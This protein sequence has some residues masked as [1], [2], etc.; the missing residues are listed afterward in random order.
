MVVPPHAAQVSAEGSEYVF[1]NSYKCKMQ[2]RQ[3][4]FKSVQSNLMTCNVVVTHVAAAN[5]AQLKALSFSR[6]ICVDAQNMSELD[7][8]AVISKN[9]NQLVLMGDH[10][11]L[12][13]VLKQRKGLFYVSRGGQIS[14][15]ERLIRQG[16]APTLLNVQHANQGQL[17]EFRSNMFY[18]SKLSYVEVRP[19]LQPIATSLTQPR[20]LLVKNLNIIN[21][22]G[23]EE[24]WDQNLFNN[25]EAEV[26]C[27]LI[28]YLL[29]NGLVKVQDIGVI[30]A[31]QGQCERIAKEVAIQAQVRPL[32]SAV[33]VVFAPL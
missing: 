4:S 19:D 7:T 11:S 29:I 33:R 23:C 5:A 18:Q 21:V 9:C 8:F 31:F 26:V 20:N 2:H 25:Q 15:F 22:S 12:S 16:V 14:L 17:A 6:I 28:L 1:A 24:I 13:P 30:A 32:P 27:S 10:L 3:N